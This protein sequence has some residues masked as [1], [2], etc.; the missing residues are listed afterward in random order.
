MGVEACL[1]LQ[2]IGISN[3]KYYFNQVPMHMR[4]L[5]ELKS[6][7]QKDKVYTRATEAERENAER[8]PLAKFHGHFCQR[9]HYFQTTTGSLRTYDNKITEDSK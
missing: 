1:E 5:S 6:Q 2:N 8:V 3:V 9:R 7:V 4:H